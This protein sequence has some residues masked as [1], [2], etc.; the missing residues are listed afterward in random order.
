MPSEV[1][2]GPRCRWAPER[3]LA[4]AAATLVLTAA[5]AAGTLTVRVTDGKGEPVAD[6]VAVAGGSAPAAAAPRPDTAV[7]DQVDKTFV[8][9]VLAIRAGTPVLFPNQDDIR[10]HVYSFSEAKTFELPLYKGT[11]AKP[12]DFDK[13]GVVVLGCNIHDFMRGYVYVTDSPYFAVTGEDGVATLAGLPDGAYQVTVW[14]PR[15][16]GDGAA[17]RRVEV[18]GGGTVELAVEVDLKPALKIRRAPTAGGKKY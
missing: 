2:G 7:I 18:A 12:V 10:H 1:R 13:P 5:S 11:P 16:K 17:P 15:E 14:H 9:H 8:P 4:L 3:A 6:A